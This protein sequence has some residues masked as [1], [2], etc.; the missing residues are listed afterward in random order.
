[1]EI[2]EEIGKFGKVRRKSGEK[3]EVQKSGI[4]RRH[5]EIGEI[6]ER[7]RGSGEKHENPGCEI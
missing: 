6:R 5:G 4:Q 1:M 3:H 2:R 7:C